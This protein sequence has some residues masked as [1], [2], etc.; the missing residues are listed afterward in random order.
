MPTSRRRA[1]SSAS[2]WQRE[3]GRTAR[4]AAAARCRSCAAACSRRSA[5]TSRPCSASSA[6]NSAARSPAPT[7]DPR[8]FAT[9]I[10]LVAHM[11]SPQVPA[12][13]MNTRF[14]V[15][16]RAWFGGGADLTPMVAARRP[17][18]HDFHAALQAGLRRPRPDALSALQGMVRRILLPAAPQRAARRRRHLLRLSRQR[19]S[20]AR[21][22]L[23]PRRR[24]GLPRHLS[25]SSCGGT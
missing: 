3:P 9:G 6:R 21:L 17:D 24:R 20:C 5:S 12:V 4:I 1:A 14:I 10:S 15:T 7:Q 18:T 25:R 11:R 8:F 19:R 23:H 2:R 22:R 16:T 13:H